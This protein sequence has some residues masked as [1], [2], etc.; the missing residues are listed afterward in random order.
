MQAARDAHILLANCDGCDGYEIVIGA[1][2][3]TKSLIRKGIQKPAVIE[4]VNH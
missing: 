3:N 1:F 2:S 4:T